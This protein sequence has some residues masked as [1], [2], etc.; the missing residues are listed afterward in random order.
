MFESTD[1]S[2]GEIETIK[3]KL[4][5]VEFYAEPRLRRFARWESVR[6][7]NVLIKAPE[8][9]HRLKVCS[10]GSVKAMSANFCCACQEARQVIKLRTKKPAVHNH[11]L[12]AQRLTRTELLQCKLPADRQSN[13]DPIAFEQSNSFDDIVK[14]Y[15]DC[16]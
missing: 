16:Q 6:K 8:G 11:Q 12:D 10:C 7:Q 13:K 3:L 15:E 14:L 1:P 5:P 9:T 4:H 2:P